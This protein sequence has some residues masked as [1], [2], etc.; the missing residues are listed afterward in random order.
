MG[1]LFDIPRQPELRVC[2]S[3][4]CGCGRTYEDVLPSNLAPDCRARL[5]D[6]EQRD[7]EQRAKERT[8]ERWLRAAELEFQNEAGKWDDFHQL[9]RSEVAARQDRTKYP[10]PRRHF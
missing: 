4:L 5:A 10:T 9:P 6:R 7:I 8:A 1:A 2:S 3:S